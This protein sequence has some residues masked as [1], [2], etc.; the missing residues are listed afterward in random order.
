ML[1]GIEG[2]NLMRMIAVFLPA[3]ALFAFCLNFKP[4]ARLVLT[5]LCVPSHDDHTRFAVKPQ[6]VVMRKEYHVG[7]LSLGYEEP[8][9]R[10]LVGIADRIVVKL[11][12]SGDGITGNRQKTIP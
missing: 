4:L 2:T 8:V 6:N 9:E 3:V 5:Y 7:S 10:I 12:V 1:F 11:F